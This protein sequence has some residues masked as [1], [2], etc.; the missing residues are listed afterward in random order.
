MRLFYQ[1]SLDEIQFETNKVTGTVIQID[2]STKGKKLDYVNFNVKRH[3]TRRVVNI[4]MHV[5]YI[6]GINKAVFHNSSR[7]S[8]LLIKVLN[9]MRIR[10]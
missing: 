4:N 5:L 3:Y 7:A 9:G 10:V 2:K 1:W 8:F 6:H